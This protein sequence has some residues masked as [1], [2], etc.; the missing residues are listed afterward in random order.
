MGDPEFTLSLEEYN[1]ACDSIP[2][3]QPRLGTPSSPA[4][5]ALTAAEPGM[6]EQVFAAIDSPLPRIEIDVFPAQNV[7]AI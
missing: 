6:H 5:A 7:G 2:K 1:T 4:S 3:A